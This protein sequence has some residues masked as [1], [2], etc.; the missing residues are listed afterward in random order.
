[1]TQQDFLQNKYTILEKL[2]PIDLCRISVKYALIKESNA[3]EPELGAAAQVHN[4]HS[5]YGD[6]LMETLLHFV[7]PHVE[8]A[9]NLQLMPTYS[10]YRVYRPGMELKPH[11]DRPSCEISTTICLGFQ[12]V[13]SDDSYRWGMFVEP[14]TLIN[15]NPGDAIVYRGCEVDHWRE[16]F[17]AAA[18]SYQV[19]VFLHYIDKQ[20]P[21]YPQY[22]YDQR[23]GLG[24]P[25]V[26][27][28]T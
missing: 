3:Y 27:E 21:F 18:G 5:V 19:Q 1:M 20:G 10:Y 11:R 26:G 9:V 16:P 28:Q 8:N 22:S 17:D 14:N 13:N 25:H 2:I 12:Y 23:S 7:K 6:T 4:A 15:Q 24:Q